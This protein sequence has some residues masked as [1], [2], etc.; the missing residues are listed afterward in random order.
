MLDLVIRSGTVVD[1][2][3]A[4]PFAADVGVSADRIVAIGRISER[5]RS[6]I[7][8]NGCIVTP[9][10]ID[11]HT[12]YDGQ[13]SWDDEIEP[14][15]ANGVTTVI[16]GNCGVGFAP[17]SPGASQ[18]LI[19]LMEGVEDIPGT[20]LHEGI[21]WGAWETFPE[22]MDYL[23]RHSYSV[24]VGAQIPHGTVRFYTMGQRGAD[25][26][27]ATEDDIAK[28][29]SIVDS[30]MQAGALGFTS[31]RTVIHHSTNGDAVP[32]TFADEREMQ[33]L[34]M[35]VGRNERGVIEIIPGGVAGPLEATG[36]SERARPTRHAGGE[37][38][39]L[40][41]ELALMERLSVNSGRPVTFTTVLRGGDLEEQPRTLRFVREANARGAQLRPQFASRATGIISGLMGYHLFMRRPTYMKLQKLPL[42]QRV[43]EMSRPEVKA[44]ILSER[45]QTFGAAAS[46]QDM[47][48]GL[49]EPLLV[50]TFRM[51][52]PLNY[53]PTEDLSI[54]A[55]ARA[56]GCQPM[57]HMYDVL[58]ENGGQSFVSVLNFNFPTYS[59]DH[60]EELFRSADTVIGLGDAGAHVNFICDMSLPTFQLV[61]W[62]RDRSRGN[63]LPLELV[64]AKQTRTNALLY[65]LRDRGALLPGLRADL[66]VIDFEHLK[67]QLPVMRHDLPAGGTRIMQQAGGYVATLVAGEVIRRH[68]QD[69]GARPGRLVR[70]T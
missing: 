37:H 67:M 58:L 35:A 2:T 16:M 31:S 8:A 26:E 27:P 50:C 6:E 42:E 12:H 59:L 15:A 13:V 38:T 43:R 5:G 36:G 70:A 20:A 41:A 63:R 30:A 24:D 44:A 3:G 48:L 40:S 64:V 10:W 39:T 17:V 51:T 56:A 21:P 68:D 23:A 45:N 54:A 66:N 28:M 9:G 25:N 65:G 47:M 29:A 60:C 46:P 55:L 62:V 18:A 22:Y 32:G 34:A 53:E 1:G 52:E 61:H 4:E 11:I 33:A 49:L 19:D 69:T 57:E 7:D 14:S